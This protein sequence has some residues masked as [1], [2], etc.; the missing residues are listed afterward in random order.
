MD[1]R[2]SAPFPGERGGIL[3]FAS[4][5][6]DSPTLHGDCDCRRKRQDIHDNENISTLNGRLRSAPSPFQAAVIPVLT[7]PAFFQCHD[8]NNFLSFE[9]RGF[10]LSF[11]RPLSAD[12]QSG[13]AGERRGYG[14]IVVP[15]SLNFIYASFTRLF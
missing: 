15:L 12:N 4:R 14:E 2:D 11:L 7:E 6:D 5:V 10:T 1:S 8:K 13:Y 9:F 3:I